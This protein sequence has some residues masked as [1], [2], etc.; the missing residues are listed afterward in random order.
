MFRDL[1]RM[2]ASLKGARY[3]GAL[4]GRAVWQRRRGRVGDGLHIL[5]DHHGLLDIVAADDSGELRLTILLGRRAPQRDERARRPLQM[6]AEGVPDE[7][8][9]SFCF[10][11]EEVHAFVEDVGD[12]NPLHA[13]D[14]PLVPGLEILEASLSREEICRAARVELRFHGASFAGEMVLVQVRSL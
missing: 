5:R 9:L 11:A 1:A 4:I 10:S 14:A 3:E 12:T 6:L 2:T 7:M 8:Q 13:G